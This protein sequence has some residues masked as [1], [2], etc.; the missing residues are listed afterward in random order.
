MDEA[1]SSVDSYSEQ[2]IQKAINK[3]TTGRTSIIIA[4]RLATIKKADQIIVM[5]KGLI[6]EQGTHRELLKKENGYYKNLY[7]VQ[8]MAETA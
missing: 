5:E 6:V 3:I 1:T 8:F 7:E 2:L 4:H